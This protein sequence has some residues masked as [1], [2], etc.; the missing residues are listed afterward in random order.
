MFCKLQLPDNKITDYLRGYCINCNS[1]HHKCSST[2]HVTCGHREGIVFKA[3]DWP[4]PIRVTCQKCTQNIQNKRAPKRSNLPDVD[5]GQEV[6]AKNKNNRY[7]YGKISEK[8]VQVYHHVHFVDN[9]FIS[10]LVNNDFLVNI[11]KIIC[12]NHF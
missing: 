8:S 9:S 3:G 2:F 11:L 10:D 6:L 4:H 7:Y 5:V 1:G 12:L